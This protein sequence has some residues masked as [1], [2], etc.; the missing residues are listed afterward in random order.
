MTSWSRMALRCPSHV[1]HSRRCGETSKA[2]GTTFDH[3]TL[4][5]CQ[6]EEPFLRTTQLLPPGTTAVFKE[7]TCLLPAPAGGSFRQNRGK[8][9]CSIQA[10]LKVVSVPARFLRTWD[11][12]L[13]GE[14]SRFGAAGGDLQRF[15]LRGTMTRDAYTR[16]EETD[17]S[18]TPY[19][20]RFITITRQQLI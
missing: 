20:L 6:T 10:I 4:W 12:L 7:I 9:G 18:F 14:V 17:E 5:F 11:A 13:C 3:S 15:F 16:W 8:V 2:T 19:V 1:S